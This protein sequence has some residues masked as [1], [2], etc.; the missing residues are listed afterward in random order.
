MVEKRGEFFRRFLCGKDGRI[1]LTRRFWRESFP[2][3][4]GGGIDPLDPRG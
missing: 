3:N 4:S 1:L 2:P